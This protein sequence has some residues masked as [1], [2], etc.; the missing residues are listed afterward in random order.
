M[1]EFFKKQIPKKIYFHD[2]KR[3]N[4]E[5]KISNF[6]NFCY[7]RYKL[8]NFSINFFLIIFFLF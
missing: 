4:L 1:I 8:E 7:F 3:L 5:K 2:Q 6:A